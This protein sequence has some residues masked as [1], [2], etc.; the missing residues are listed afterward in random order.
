[1]QNKCSIQYEKQFAVFTFPWE[2]M[3]YTKCVKFALFIPK[4][5]M[6]T[7]RVHGDLLTSGQ[8]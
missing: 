8:H 1:M 5:V 4:L 7:L 3:K 2:K 6:V